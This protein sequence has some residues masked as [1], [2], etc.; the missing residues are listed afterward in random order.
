MIGAACN[1]KRWWRRVTWEQQEAI[2][3]IMN[4]QFAVSPT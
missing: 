3:A 2:K 4:E 1:I